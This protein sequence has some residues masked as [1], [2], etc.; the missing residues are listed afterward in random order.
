[1]GGFRS[2]PAGSVVPHK[3]HRPSFGVNLLSKK[4]M[5]G[6]PKCVGRSVEAGDAV[7]TRRTLL[8]KFVP[9][10]K[11]QLRLLDLFF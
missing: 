8:N 3:S 2:L 6:R 7:D 9:G 4:Q 10:G 5:L 11:P 1:M